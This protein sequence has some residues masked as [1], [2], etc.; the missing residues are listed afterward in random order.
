MTRYELLKQ[1]MKER[2]VSFVWLAA[3]LGIKETPLRR[4]LMQDRIPTK[5]HAQLVHIGI[6]E[7]MLPPGIDL[8]SRRPVMVPMLDADGRILQVLPEGHDSTME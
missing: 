7:D 4:M 8:T 2:N 3:Q 5:R 1:W 6:P